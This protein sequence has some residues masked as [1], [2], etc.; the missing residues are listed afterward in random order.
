MIL[1][2]LCVENFIALK[3]AYSGIDSPDLCF[4]KDH[5]N[6]YPHTISYN[7][8]S[9]GFRDQEWPTTQ[10]ELKQAIW[11][12]GDSFTVGVGSAFEHTWPQRL[13]AVTGQRCINIAM[14]GASNQW[15]ARRAGQ[16]CREIG[17][18]NIVIQWSYIHRREQ[19]LYL[20]YEQVWQHWYDRH[21]AP[22]WPATSLAKFHS[23]PWELQLEIV[24]DKTWPDWKNETG[25]NLR[26]MHAT[27]TTH[28]QDIEFTV[29]CWKLLESTRQNT[30][31]IHSVIPGFAPSSVVNDFRQAAPKPY[32]EIQQQDWA[33]DGH[34]YGQQTT[35]TFV[36]QLVNQL[37]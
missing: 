8:N 15:I 13:A 3:Q 26:A 32:I 33:R 20:R 29:K 14:D 17:A 34:H 9:R 10:D 4:D 11:C 7:Y 5:F 22:H 6:E 18:K 2:D 1:P 21:R 23:L 25:D 19:D 12:V 27:P 37:V 24:I 30:K 28:Q 16:I 36:Q 31:I 35:E